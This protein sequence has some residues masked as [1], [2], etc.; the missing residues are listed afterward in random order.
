MGFTAAAT[1]RAL[2]QL[3]AQQLLA[4]QAMDALVDVLTST[5]FNATPA[6]PGGHP[7]APPRQ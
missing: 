2:G 6:G 1:Q 3:S 4:P 7:H 5:Q